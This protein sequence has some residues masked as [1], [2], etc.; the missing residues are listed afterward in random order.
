[1]MLDYHALTIDEPKDSNQK[2]YQF[3]VTS[4]IMI[5]G[6]LYMTIPAGII[7]PIKITEGTFPGGTFVY[8]TTNRDYV[9]AH[10]LELCVGDNLE[11]HPN[12]FVDRIYTIYLD[13]L[14]KVKSG[15]AHRFAS[16]YLSNSS[17]SDR[18]LE[19]TLMS[20]NDAMEPLDLNDVESLSADDL[21]ERL[22]YKK[23][24]LP[25]TKAAVVH[26]P[27]TN[28][29]VSSIIMQF[30]ILP[31]LRKYAT[32]A[33]LASGKNKASV[34]IITTC[35]IKHQVC[36]HYAPL[37]NGEPFLL[38]LLNTDEYATSI[39]APKGFIASIME[40]FPGSSQEL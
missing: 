23:N 34:V 4:A 7:A 24:T 38:G 14:S 25:K 19:E 27:S 20:L 39:P 10:S 2:K 9:A 37:E 22:R 33:Q 18:K 17:Q 6:F 11:I 35:H 30:R 32:E 26:F 13:D 40:I 36:T 21:W 5:I 29:F 12:D 1:M 3:R 31:T 8:K 15:G 16:G 28:G